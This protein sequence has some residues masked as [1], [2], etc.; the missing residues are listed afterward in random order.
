MS[1]RGVIKLGKFF[2]I[3][4]GQ[5]KVDQVSTYDLFFSTASSKYG[6]DSESKS[7]SFKEYLFKDEEL[8]GLMFEAANKSNKT[9]SLD[10][11]ISVK[12]S[13]NV[14]VSDNS[15]YKQKIQARVIK[16]YESFVGKPLQSILTM[17]TAMIAK[18]GG[19]GDRIIVKDLE[20]DPG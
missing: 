14:I 1:I 7:E 15:S 16:V 10:V 18:G 4:L 17:A 19:N 12:P 13:F 6:Q 11:E 5:V 3:K 2:E 20:V 9:V 8:I